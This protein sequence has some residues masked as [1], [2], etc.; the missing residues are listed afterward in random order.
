MCQ[1]IH[2]LEDQF[3]P[4]NSMDI[5]QLAY[6]VAEK[7]NIPHRFNKDSAVA[8]EDWYRGFVKR[9]PEVCIKKPD[10]NDKVK[11]MRKDKVHKFF[12]LLE[13]IVDKHQL[14]AS[15]IYNLDETVITCSLDTSNVAAS[16]NTENTGE[17]NTSQ[18]K[19]VTATVCFSASGA[20]VPLMLIFPCPTKIK[21]VLKGAPPGA[22]AEYDQSGQMQLDIFVTWLK[23]FIKFSKSSI[24][25][26]VLLIV[27]GYRTYLKKLQ[28][29]ELAKENGVNI[30]CLPPY[31][32]ENLQP[33][34]QDF[35]KSLSTAYTTEVA[36]WTRAN[37]G[38]LVSIEKVYQLFGNAF[39]KVSTIASPVDG[40]RSTGI[41]PADRDRFEEE[42]IEITKEGLVKY[43]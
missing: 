23:K 34:Q 14:E 21:S 2:T 8:G 36:K 42:F 9:N 40:F 7:F 30:L 10:T 38:C 41:W 20:Y 26:P 6:Q 27:D 17:S 3:I 33:M 13:G 32:T 37:P 18:S 39:M 11:G 29:L 24:D 31:C 28:V 1:Y 25:S 12:D 43:S 16:T 22:W 19:L 5:R 15:D 4:F 35:M